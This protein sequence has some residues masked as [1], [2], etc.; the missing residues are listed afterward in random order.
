MKKMLTAVAAAGLVVAPAFAQTQTTRFEHNEAEHNQAKQSHSQ[1]LVDHHLAYLTTVLSLS[2]TQQDQAKNIL[3]NAENQNKPLFNNIKTERKDL[4]SAVE[5]NEP[6]ST[7]KPLSDKI[8]KDVSQL[9]MNEATAGEQLYKILTPEQA[10]KL[11]Q[12]QSE[13]FGRFAMGS[14]GSEM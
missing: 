9:A 1:T 10:Q 13:N 6:T 3:T 8:G 7:I 5:K 11:T 12:L 14:G 2:S 4:R